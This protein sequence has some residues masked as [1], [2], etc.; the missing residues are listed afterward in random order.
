M[1]HMKS[2]ESDFLKRKYDLH[3]APEVESAAKRTEFHTKEKVPQDPS[4]RIENYLNR[5][6]EIIDREIQIWSGY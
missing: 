3:T 6:R 2:P 5:F 1:R 4:V